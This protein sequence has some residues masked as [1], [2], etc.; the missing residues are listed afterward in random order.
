MLS[1]YEPD[2]GR[3][4]R[5]HDAILSLLDALESEIAKPAPA[6]SL[7]GVRAELKSLVFR[8]LQEEDWLIFPWLL[9]HNRD[10]LAR[11][12]RRIIA[13]HGDFQGAV[14][15]HIVRWPDGGVAAEWELYGRSSRRLINL[16]RLRIEIEE[17]QLYTALRREDADAA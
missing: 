11:R 8:H 9:T 10:D 6:E 15:Q 2:L 14:A 17:S 13:E 12:T 16:L 3:I 4:R 5:D 7:V 1:V